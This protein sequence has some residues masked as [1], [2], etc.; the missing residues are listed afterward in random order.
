MKTWMMT[1]FAA[2]AAVA[3]GVATVAVAGDKADKAEKKS[4]IG[5]PAPAFSLQDQNGQTV[6]LDDYKGKLVV[7][8]W[9]NDECPFVV[10]HYQQGHMQKLAKQYAEK[11]VVWL[12]INTTKSH[13]AAHNKEVAGK[14]NIDRPILDDSKEQTVGKAY[15]ATNTPH[16]Y[17][18]DKNGTIAYAGAIDSN[19]SSD[20]KDIEGATNYVAKALDELLSG[21]NVS[22]P[23]TKAYGCTVKYSK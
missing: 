14:W 17:V 22:Q 1:A 21:S 6:S 4:L 7:L 13:D 3:L 18:I 12:A 20:T 8:E 5:Q 10:K 16:M 19:R 15:G 2:V 23:E 11:D 9:F